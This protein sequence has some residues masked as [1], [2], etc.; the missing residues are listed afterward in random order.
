MVENDR[1]RR[2]FTSL[3]ET[4]RRYV[5]ESN[6]DIAVELSLEA[7]VGLFALITAIE[8]GK[9]HLVSVNAIAL[10]KYIDNP[11]LLQIGREKL[12]NLEAGLL[13][14]SESLKTLSSEWRRNYRKSRTVMK[15]RTTTDCDSKGHCTTSTEF[16]TE[17]E[18]YWDEPN[19]WTS[20]GLDHN[21]ISSWQNS[22][23]SQINSVN[24][25]Y[26]SL[27]NTPTF[28]DGY[29]TY[30]VTATPLDTTK[31][32]FITT[33]GFASASVGFAFYEEVI[34]AL[35]KYYGGYDSI[36][37]KFAN[38]R[39]KR[40]SFLKFIAGS[41]AIDKLKEWNTTFAKE[42]SGVKEK[43]EG[44]IKSTIKN[45][46]LNDELAIQTLL[47]SNINSIIYTHKIISEILGAALN[48]NGNGIEDYAVIRPL[49]D[50]VVDQ[51]Q[52]RGIILEAYTKN[53]NTTEVSQELKDIASHVKADRY[54][55][56]LTAEQ[57]S[58]A[59]W[60]AIL[61]VVILIGAFTGIAL[62]AEIALVVTDEVYRNF[63]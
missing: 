56:S 6:T 36:L 29:D 40:R 45:I 25:S 38:T 1:R 12:N 59:T 61:Q 30:R 43:I 62:T 51:N 60:N 14:L 7:L 53:G 22:I 23:N 19:E 2:L 5:E 24:S 42:N 49:L 18:Y 48:N 4:G 34:T 21:T 28:V 31:R 37:R 47:G 26:N 20:L 41:F 15:S 17:T 27:P 57:Q 54:I 10:D 58:Q 35:A 52:N 50:N 33:I 32:S 63:N 8:A 11:Q 39:V 46:K 55:Q 16:Y 9:T 13:E 3:I 44:E